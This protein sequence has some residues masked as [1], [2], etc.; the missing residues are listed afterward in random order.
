MVDEGRKLSRVYEEISFFA[1]TTASASIEFNKEIDNNR[2][3]L[4]CNLKFP[5]GEHRK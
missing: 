1:A 5:A 4:S 3:F 2:I